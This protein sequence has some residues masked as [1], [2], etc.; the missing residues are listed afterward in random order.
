MAT[1]TSW[2][3]ARAHG[4]QEKRR[5]GAGGADAGPTVATTTFGTGSEGAGADG[6]DDA[7]VGKTDGAE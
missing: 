7:A 2:W 5:Q 6:T 1:L 3:T 4:A